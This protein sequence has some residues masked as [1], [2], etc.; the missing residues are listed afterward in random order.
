MFFVGQHGF[1]AN[2]SC[3]TALHEVITNCLNNLD[4][5]LINLLLFIDFKKAFDM[6]DSSLLIIKLLNYGFSNDA[7]ELI[8]SYFIDRHQL[9]KLDNSYSNLSKL[10]LGVPQGS[11]LGPLLFLIFINDLPWY[12]N[13]IETTLFADDT[14]LLFCEDN[15]DRIISQYKNGL[16]KLNE[17]CN[18]N[19]LYINWSKTYIMVITNKRITVPNYVEFDSVKV[20][21]IDKFKLLGV[22]IDNKLH[23]ND[24]VNQQC[25]SIN[26]KLFAIK[27]L[28]YLP[29][30]VKMQFF[31]T[32]ILPYF[33]YCIS[34]SIYYSTIALKKLCKSY[35]LCL[36]NLF[37]FRFTKYFSTVLQVPCS[38][39]EINTMLKEHNLFSFH[40]RMIYRISM[41]IHKVI[42]SKNA[43]KKLNEWLKI[44]TINNIKYSLRS[45]NTKKI[46]LDR[47]STKFGDLTFKNIFGR[48]INKTEFILEPNFKQFKSELIKK[49]DQQLQLF[50]NLNKKFENDLNYFFFFI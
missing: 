37:N 17:W 15:F 31:K 40:H 19:R 4:K 2:H 48:F 39:E 23:F 5:K 27:R 8:K 34:L 11:V 9:I 44:S 6:V 7:I 24:Y 12:L 16:K 41:F 30:E 29:F 28:F 10:L 20:E 18:H 26:K 32:F 38:H 13:Q 47:N 43:P 36:K 25:I 1:R 21:I 49:I 35:Y 14:T 46:V 3:E 33:D 45:N 22:L 42:Y 50:L